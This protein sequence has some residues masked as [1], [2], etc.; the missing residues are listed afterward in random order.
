MMPGNLVLWHVS[1][2]S[3]GSWVFKTPTFGTTMP[4]NLN[5]IPHTW[6]QG[7]IHDWQLSAETADVPL[8]FPYLMV[9]YGAGFPAPEKGLVY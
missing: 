5:L 1:K 6:K 8:P 4:K 3:L 2:G 9:E 7:A